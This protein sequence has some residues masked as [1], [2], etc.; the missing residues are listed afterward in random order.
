MTLVKV[1]NPISKTLDGFV[2]D[3]FNDFPATFG[4]TFCEDVLG[5]PHL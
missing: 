4:R 1:N 3:I 2:N 5:F